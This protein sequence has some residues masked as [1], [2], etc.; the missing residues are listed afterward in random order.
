MSPDEDAEIWR[1]AREVVEETLAGL[2]EDLR[3]ASAHCPVRLELIARCPDVSAGDEDLLGLFEG[4]S[5]LEPPPGD[6]GDMP[7]IRLFLD[8]LWDFA[9]EDA[10]V[11]AEEVETTLL[12]ELAHFLGLDEDEVAERGLA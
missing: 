3:D 12:H 8:N 9:E 1:I 6:A 7:R 10:E 4:A 11:F 2:P 5:L